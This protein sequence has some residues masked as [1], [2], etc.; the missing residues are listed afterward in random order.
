MPRI[1][2][3]AL[4]VW[5][6]AASA[7]ESAATVPTVPSPA[8][9]T[10]NSAELPTLLILD[11]DPQGVDKEQAS[12]LTDA[13]VAALSQRGLFK[14]VSTR[15]VQTLISTERQRQLL[16]GC[17]SPECARD[18]GT[19]ANARYVLN[20]SLSKVG[21]AYQLA[22]QA[23]DS[24]KNAPLGRSIRIANDLQTLVGLVPYA[25]SEATGTPLPPPKPR[26]VQYSMI[27]L[28]SALL[29]SGGG[30]GMFAVSRQ[31]ILNSEL[32]PTGGPGSNG[33][34]GGVNLR[35]REAYLN[36]DRAIAAQ[37][38]LSLLMLGVGAGL[39]AAGVV[40]MPAPEGGPRMAMT[41]TPSGVGLAGVF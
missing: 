9:V 39:I 33:S 3:F 16:T 31:Q 20:G 17:D 36:D 38:T 11:I 37:K 30:V 5:S 40:L 1:A 22:L 41:L 18:M 4:V 29:V 26:W 35:T 32:C 27:G 34:C 23:L 13:V 19:A 6:A 12:A 15:D 28:G 25:A 24:E 2:T 14:V 7:E 8:K 10:T 21:A